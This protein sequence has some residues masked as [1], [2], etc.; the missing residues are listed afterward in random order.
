MVLHQIIFLK[1]EQFWI[2]KYIWPVF[3]KAPGKAL[4]SI[5]QA[6][7][8]F[9]FSLLV[10]K[11]NTPFLR[12]LGTK[13]TETDFWLLS[14][15]SLC[16]LSKKCPFLKCAGPAVV[17]KAS[18]EIS[19]HGNEA[20]RGEVTCWRLR[21]RGVSTGQVQGKLFIGFQEVIAHKLL[22]P[23]H[24]FSSKTEL[25]VGKWLRSWKESTTSGNGAL[26]RGA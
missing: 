21:P 6:F 1:S 19:G 5:F 15:A 25:V 3:P 2:L 11:E 24:M 12:K 18:T 26:W 23:N 9:S 7:L 10:I 22:C 16:T 14:I 13:E 20:W 8:K 17:C 4:Y